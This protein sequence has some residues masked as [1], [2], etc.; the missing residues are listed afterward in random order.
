MLCFEC[1]GQGEEVILAMSGLLRTASVFGCRGCCHRCAR[2]KCS[3]IVCSDCDAAD[4]DDNSSVFCEKC[5]V[6][7]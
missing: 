7:L 5:S 4:A 2:V 3:F 1:D 6:A